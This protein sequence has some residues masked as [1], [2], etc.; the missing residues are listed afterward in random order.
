MWSAGCATA[1]NNWCPTAVDRHI[2]ATGDYH[3]ET[4]LK[5]SNIPEDRAST[6]SPD[7]IP[8]TCDNC[9]K[10]NLHEHSDADHDGI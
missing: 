1:A 7:G 3:I 10:V 8:D 5:S 2:T 9:P 4:D 6:S